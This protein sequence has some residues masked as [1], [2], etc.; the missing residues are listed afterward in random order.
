MITN[1]VCEVLA[2]IKLQ[3]MKGVGGWMGLG[4]WE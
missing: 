1:T 3:Y 4:I 2:V